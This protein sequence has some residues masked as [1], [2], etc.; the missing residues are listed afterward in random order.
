MDGGLDSLTELR[1]QRW[2][3]DRAENLGIR[4]RDLLAHVEWEQAL[5]LYLDDTEVA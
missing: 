1:Y 4:E 3:T 5:R 2:V